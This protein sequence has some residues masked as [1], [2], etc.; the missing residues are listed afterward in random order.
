MICPLSRVGKLGNSHRLV[1]VPG[2]LCTIFDS[3]AVRAEA[4]IQRESA[5]RCLSFICVLNVMCSVAVLSSPEAC[6]P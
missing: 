2:T 6:S 4:S 3:L 1:S 5:E